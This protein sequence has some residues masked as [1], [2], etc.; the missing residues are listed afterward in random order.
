MRAVTLGRS[1]SATRDRHP[2]ADQR[3]DRASSAARDSERGRALLEEAFV[4]AA[5]IGARRSRR[6]RAREPRDG[7]ARCAA[8]TTGASTTTSSARCASPASASWTATSSTCS[9][10]APRCAL[11]P[12]RL[13]RRRGRRA[14]ARSRWA[15]SSGVSQCPA[16]IV[17][18]PAGRPARRAGGGASA[19]AGVGARG[20]DPGA[21][22]ARPGR[23]GAGGARLAGRRPRRRRGGRAAG[24]RARGGAGRR[25]G[26][27]GA[28][29]AGCGAAGAPVPAREDDPAPYA[30]QHRRRL[31]GGGGR[32]GRD[33]LPVRPR[34]GALGG[35][36][37]AG[38][39]R[40]AR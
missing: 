18:G 19:R 37:G 28:G 39:A 7:D 24:V 26:A 12:R 27:R 20:G 14:R 8:A 23:V 16:L 30:L 33:R 25:L 29:A 38:A 31:A 15:S 4:L 40:G 13:G 35:R 17:L 6:P 21:A 32:L 5:A 3:R 36:R 1:A 2:R 10:C 9:A 11:L 22:A 34:R